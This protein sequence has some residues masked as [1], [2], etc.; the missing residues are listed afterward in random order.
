MVEL[1][2]GSSIGIRA[3]LESS[4]DLLLHEIGQGNCMQECISRCLDARVLSAEMLEGVYE[5]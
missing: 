1:L 4:S 3:V 2:C 5:S